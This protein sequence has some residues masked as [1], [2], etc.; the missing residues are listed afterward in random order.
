M[1]TPTET[2]QLDLATCA[3]C[4]G[5]VRGILQMNLYP[6]GEAV[7]NDLEQRGACVALKACNGSGKTSVIGAGAALW[8]AAIFRSSLTICTAG[9]FRQ[10][11]E[12]LFPTIRAHAHKF[13]GWSF[14]ETE[15]TTNTKSR[16][17]GFSTD[18]PGRF[19]GWHAQNLLMIVDEAKTVADSIFEAIER[20]QP[21]R[22]L[23]L[24]SP[25]GCSGFFYQAFNERRKFFKQHTV[26]A[27]SCPHILPG[28]VQQ[29]IEKYGEEHPLV[30]SMIF[31]EFMTSGQDSSVI[32]LSF[33]ERCMA[34]P[35]VAAG[36]D[37][38]AFCDF[39]A[40]GDENVLAVRRGNAVTIADAWR[41]KDTMKGVGRFINLF[42][43]NGLEAHQ[44]SGDESGL[45]GVMCDRLAEVGWPISRVNNG[46]AAYDDEHYVN[47]G[48]E[49]W[50]EGRR[51]VERQQIILPNDKE[52]IAQLTSRRGWPD[53]KGR[54]ALEKKEDLAKRNLP[55][56]DRADAVLGTLA[57]SGKNKGALS[58]AKD[59]IIGNNDSRF[60]SPRVFVPRHFEPRRLK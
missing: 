35:P 23:L 5:F 13:N 12:Q 16:I 49:M 47:L 48:A 17:L 38:A 7:L 45:G 8:H 43:L 36:H 42:K 4:S 3:T 40:G 30:R 33:L 27:N 60:G 29:Q 54:L 15:V 51:S 50:Y 41:D 56:P 24:S 32:P 52:L 26:S 34:A 11:K 22:L 59:I 31:A 28:W 53:S 25:G 39:A 19:E 10:V 55:S 58:G 57:L 9:V 20:C 2:P 1:A 21:T 44:I 46:S 18:D 6:W 37:V 14:L